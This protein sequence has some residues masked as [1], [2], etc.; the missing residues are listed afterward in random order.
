[1]L[2][3]IKRPKLGTAGLAVLACGLLCATAIALPAAAEQPKAEVAASPGQ[4]AKKALRTARSAK[5]LATRALNATGTTP[6]AF[7]GFNTSLPI[8]AK[9]R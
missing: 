3:H 1:M 2:N 9:S 7:I 5:R 4:T 8:G 6:P